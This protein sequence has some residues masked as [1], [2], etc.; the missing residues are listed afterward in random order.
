MN[1]I[2]KV[3]NPF[4]DKDGFP[5]LE[6]YAIDNTHIYLKCP[7]SKSTYHL[8]GSCGDLTNRYE[9][10]GSHSKFFDNYY[11]H[12][13]DNTIRGSMRNKRVLKRSMK[14]MNKLWLKQK[15]DKQS[16]V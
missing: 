2:G 16:K 14:T 6:A 10:R 11:I 9:H 13:T 5:V 8:H 3:S 7:Y 15:K 4:P 12:I 1:S